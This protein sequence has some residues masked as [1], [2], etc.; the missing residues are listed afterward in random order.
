MDGILLINKPEGITSFDVCY[1]I[2]KKLRVK[3]VGHGGT[4]DPFA[5]GLLIV[6][7][8]KATRILNFFSEAPKIY[9]GTIILGE[10]RDSYDI[11]GNIV[12]SKNIEKIF[13]TED[14]ILKVR[15]E[16]LGA[17]KQKPPVFSALKH[18]GKA[19]YKYARKGVKIDKEPRDIF[20]ESFDIINFNFP[21]IDFRIKCSKGTYIRS[22]ANDFGV[23]LGTYGYL[24]S[25][26]REAIGTITVKKAV[27][28]ESVTENNIISFED[29]LPFKKLFVNTEYKKLLENGQDINFE[30]IENLTDNLTKENVYVLC[31]NIIA[32]GSLDFDN[33]TVKVNI[34]YKK[35]LQ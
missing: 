10:K 11:T 34:V 6:G 33:K 8:N 9:T 31:E 20:I 4:L 32:I 23:K 26:N 28:I 27:E 24:H 25:L 29:S 15:D 17:I 16:F 7:I 21:A 30:Y 22:I 1:K 13:M 12:E 35:P 3:K 14:D 5:T 2:R 19:L 18:K